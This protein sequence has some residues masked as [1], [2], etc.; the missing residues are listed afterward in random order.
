M[1]RALAISIGILLL[2]LLGCEDDP[3][4]PAHDHDGHVHP[5]TTRLD[6]S[7]D[8]PDAG[9]P[10]VNELLRLPPGFPVPVIPEDNPLTREKVELGRRLFYDK[11]LSLNETQSCATCHD[12]SKG[13]AE[14]IAQSVGSTG[15][16]HPR[17][18]MGL[19]NVAYLNVLTWGNPV[20]D[21]LERQILAPMFGTQPIELGF[22]DGDPLVAR[23]KTIPIY[24]DAFADAYPGD[25]D[26]ITLE[27]IVF[28]ITSFERTLISGR[29]P[30]DRWLYGGESDAISESAKRGYELFNGHP[31]E[32]FHCH[33]T[34]NFADSV[35]WEGNPTTPLFH[36]TGLYNVGG[37][38]AYPEP[39]TGIHEIT[40]NPRDMGR[41][42]APTLRNIAVTAPYM[43]DGSIA[44]L[45]EVLDHY[46]AGGRTISEGPYAGDGSQNPYK[47]EFI[48]GF[49]LDAQDRADLIAFLESLTDEEF[50]TDPA[51]SDP[52]AE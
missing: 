2:P 29:S 37:N 12:Q 11:R 38:G 31:F 48:T 33:N 9:D 22:P 18:S 40:Q 49:P 41:F 10:V 34:F 35:M 21:V 45:S 17:N 51:F 30:F 52:W 15:E 36:N 5:P 16:I 19:T 42:R 1:R 23:L 26:P 43:H 39:N 4:P 47:S 6:G 14:D 24:V 25:E 3:V 32:C 50:L 20:M 27:N 44:T 46:A 28:A 13:F 8:A 7:V